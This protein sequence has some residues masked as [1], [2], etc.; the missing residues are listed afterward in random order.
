M[1]YKIPKSSS[2]GQ[3]LMALR[4]RMI[5]ANQAAY[6]LVQSLGAE[7]FRPG[8]YTVAG[9]VLSIIFPEGHKFGPDKNVWKES[10]VP[11]EYLP[12]ERSKK[13]KLI[14]DLIEAL[15]RVLRKELNTLVGYD[16]EWNVIGIQWC[17]TE[18]YILMN[19]KESFVAK[20]PED[21]EEIS[22]AEWAELSTPRKE[23]ENG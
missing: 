11:G 18:D 3:K 8:Q 10:E 22:E 21:C 23:V 19:L 9:G 20:V 16:H 1:F 13:G 5:A 14:A 6:E 12:N 17:S 2:T 15:P 7:S 4:E